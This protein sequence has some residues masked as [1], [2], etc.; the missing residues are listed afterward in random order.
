MGLA[1]IL[2]QHDL[3]LFPA[4]LIKCDRLA[5]ASGG[6]PEGHGIDRS[7]LGSVSSG[8]IEEADRGVTIS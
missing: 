7:K 3:R 1:E 4:G 2:D 6:E 5:I 8:K